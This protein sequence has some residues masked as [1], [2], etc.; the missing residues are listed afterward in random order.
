M[1]FDNN[2]D[3]DTAVAETITKIDA[4]AD[5]ADVDIEIFVASA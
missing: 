4:L 5:T 3:V 2:S 1:G